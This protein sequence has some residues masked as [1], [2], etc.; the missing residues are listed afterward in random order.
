MLS[1][2]FRKRPLF[3]LVFKEPSNLDRFKS[4]TF[5]FRFLRILSV[6]R[7]MCVQ[8]GSRYLSRWGNNTINGTSEIS[9]IALGKKKKRELGLPCP[10]L[11]PCPPVPASCCPLQHLLNIKMPIPTEK[12][13]LFLRSPSSQGSLAGDLSLLIGI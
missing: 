11:Q 8:F 3:K 5:L 2:P 6:L 1:I 9:H 10:D 12:R 7:V 4:L 13:K